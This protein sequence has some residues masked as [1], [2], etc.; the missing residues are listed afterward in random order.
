MEFQIIVLIFIFLVGLAVSYFIGLKLGE[1]RR[2]NFWLENLKNHRKDAVVRSRSILVGQFSEQMSPFLP[3]FK[4][5]P[6][7][8]K[9]IGKPIDFIV[10]EGSS[11]GEISKITFLEVKSG[12]SKLSSKEKSLKRTIE[13]GNVFWDEYRVPGL[14]EA[15]GSV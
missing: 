10:F 3:N 8:C 1:V 9:F 6:A 2:E 11:E 12:K 5:N 14:K 7:D 13:E 4:F 15:G